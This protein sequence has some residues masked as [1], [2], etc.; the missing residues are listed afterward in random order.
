MSRLL[1]FQ[2]ARFLLLA[3]AIA[4]AQPVSPDVTFRTGTQ[5]VQIGV[6]A[7]AS[8]GNPAAGLSREDFQILDNG[9]PQEI[10]L[11]LSGQGATRVQEAAAPGTFSNKIATE[12]SGA[13]SVLLFD[14]LNMDPGGE[15][16]GHT[17]RARQKALQ[18]LA[19]IPAGDKIAIYSLWCQF[20]VIR[21]FTSDRDSLLRQLTAFTP[22]SAP[23]VDPSNGEPAHVSFEQL[24]RSGP[25]RADGTAGVASVGGGGRPPSDASTLADRS[26]EKSEHA[27]ASILADIADQEMKQMAEH[28]AGIPGRKNLIWLSTN[29]RISPANLRRLID[30]EVAAYPVD[31]VGSTIAL[32]TEK[33]AHAAPLQALAA[34]TGGVAFVDRDDLDSVVREALDDGRLSYTLGYYQ[35]EGDAGS[36]HQVSVRVNRPGVTLRYRTSYAVEAQPAASGDPIHDLVQ[37]MNRPVNATAITMTASAARMEDRLDVSLTFDISGMDFQ[38]SDEL[39]KGKAQVLTRFL[40]A[41]G[42]Q[43]GDTVVNT[44]SFTLLP[45]S[46]AAALEKGARYHKEIAIPANAVELDVLVS[47]VANGKIGTL[48]IPLSQVGK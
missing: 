17:A 30:A 31:T 5:L 38:L 4:A 12:G 46:Y 41:E 29:F 19:K 9:A 16:F 14:N 27:A 6:V 20:Q 11:F 39:W 34:Q 10:R 25:M 43:A 1:V 23:C 33:R 22:A 21:E 2:S 37:A 18:A 40:T 45:A 42:A 44:M 13:Y 26:R 15:V 36:I 24:S 35:P 32:A 48:K 28:L 8:D 3:T 7:R 47:S